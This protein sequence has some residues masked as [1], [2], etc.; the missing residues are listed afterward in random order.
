VDFGDEYNDLAQISGAD[1]FG[2]PIIVV[3]SSKVDAS[4]E[5]AFV[6]TVFY[7][8]ALARENIDDH[9]SFSVAYCDDAENDKTPSSD[10]LRGAYTLIPKHLRKNM[11]HL[12]CINSSQSLRMW[13][14]KFSISYEFIVHFNPCHARF[15]WF[16]N[17][18]VSAKFAQ[19]IVHVMDTADMAEF[20]DAEKTKMPPSVLERL[21]QATAKKMSLA[22][23][24][25]SRALMSRQ[26]AQKAEVVVDPSPSDAVDDINEESLGSSGGIIAAAYSADTSLATDL[27]CVCFSDTLH[28]FP[29]VM[30]KV[31]KLP[32]EQHPKYREVMIAL[33]ML[34]V[35]SID[36]AQK[37]RADAKY[38]LLLSAAGSSSENRP[39]TEWL[40]AFHAQLPHEMRKNC[41]NVFIYMPSLALRAFV[42]TARLFLSSK[43]FK[44]VVNLTSESAAGEY[45]DISGADF[46]YVTGG[47][48]QR[49]ISKSS[50][51]S[52]P[53]AD[54]SDADQLRKSNDSSHSEEQPQVI[55]AVA[56]LSASQPLITR[57]R[58]VN[59]KPVMRSD[60]PLGQRSWSA[61]FSSYAP[62]VFTSEGFPGSVRS[63]MRSAKNPLGHADPED[64]HEVIHGLTASAFDEMRDSEEFIL[65]LGVANSVTSTALG[66]SNRLRFS[67]TGAMARNDKGYPLNPAGRTGLSGRAQ[68]CLWGPNHCALPIIVRCSRGERE[69]HV[70]LLMT[71]ESAASSGG[72][73]WSLPESAVAAGHIIS[74]QL[75]KELEAQAL[76]R[77][78]LFDDLS[79]QEIRSQFQTLFAAGCCSPDN[80]LH[81]GVWDDAGNTDHAWTEALCV[82]TLLEGR[83]ADSLDY[84]CENA[85]WV[86]YDPSMPVK[87]S[88]RPLIT[89]AILRLSQRGVCDVHGNASSSQGVFSL[90]ISLAGLEKSASSLFAMDAFPEQAIEEERRSYEELEKNDGL[91]AESTVAARR[92]LI[93]RY[94]KVGNASA[95]KVLQ[96]LDRTDIVGGVQSFPSG[97]SN[98]DTGGS[99]IK[100]SSVMTEVAVPAYTS[101]ISTHE[102]E[103]VDSMMRLYATRVLQFFR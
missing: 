65:S 79:Q 76:N 78:D 21:P 6:A 66:I 46:I 42:G 88:H 16:A 63:S 17:T 18:F 36:C 82:L 12:F 71:K 101:P 54:L 47:P 93:V 20:L 73:L 67:H 32:S 11:K 44:K 77:V 52:L 102:E 69:Q 34:L 90:A 87:E 72:T 100:S 57:F 95:A 103:Y 86:P 5:E 14:N 48:D 97:T 10:W 1:I 25:R 38:C 30:I 62:T 31:S 92:N 13:V 45:F 94:R 51:S 15:F 24:R 75:L 99:S 22:M 59:G 2:D 89:E 23:V 43:F 41:S 56:P 61:P 19:K 58:N 28:G 49:A 9:E 35:V 83:L 7:L 26:L 50:N 64:I 91:Y 74:P 85:I 84:G 60:V 55:P 8:L 3:D 40:R 98:G 37:K 96:E 53:V 80:T 68:H 81:A 29:C 39:S 33:F 4:S 70:Q 27:E